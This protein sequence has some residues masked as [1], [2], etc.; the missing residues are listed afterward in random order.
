MKSAREFFRKKYGER[1]TSDIQLYIERKLQDP[2]E[3]KIFLNT[4]NET[5]EALLR[6]WAGE[7]EE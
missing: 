2:S 7:V 5:R 6:E 4:R 3:A 1:Y